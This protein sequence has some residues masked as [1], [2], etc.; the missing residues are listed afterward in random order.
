MNSGLASRMRTVH[1]CQAHVS[2]ISRMSN[3]GLEEQAITSEEQAITR[4]YSPS[5][6]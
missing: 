3:N 5:A 2:A 4:I 6:L 1:C